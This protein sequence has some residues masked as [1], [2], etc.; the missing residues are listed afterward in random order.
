P[1][2]DRLHAARRIASGLFDRL[3]GD[4]VGIVV[5]AGQAFVQCPLTVDEGAARMLLGAIGQETVPLPGTAIGA[6]IDQASDVLGDE[7]PWRAIVLITD[8]EDHGGDPVAAARRAAERGI[9]IITVGIGGEAGELIPVLNESGERVGY[10][11]DQSGELVVSRLDEATLREVAEATGGRY[12]RAGNGRETDVIY[13]E[14]DAMEKRAI[15]GGFHAHYQDRFHIFA[16]AAFV[17]L[18]TARWLGERGL[19]R[20]RGG[21]RRAATRAT[22]VGALLLAPLGALGPHVAGATPAAADVERGN[23]A[24]RD[25]DPDAA[26]EHYLDALDKDDTNAAVHYNLGNAYHEAGEFEEAM[27]AYVRAGARADSGLAPAISYNLG[28]TLFREGRLQDAI[29]AYEQTLRR[30]PQDAD[31]K[32][33][34][35]VALQRLEEQQRQQDQSEQQDGEQDEQQDNQ[36]QPGNPQQEEQ[37][38]GEQ[39]QQGQQQSQEEQQENQQED[40]QQGQQ[41]DQQQ[42]QQQQ[43]QPQDDQ[44]QEQDDE[45][46]PQQDS[47]EQPENAPQAPAAEQPPGDQEPPA[48]MSPEDARRWLEALNDDELQLLRERFRSRRQRLDVEKDW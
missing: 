15:E 11:R 26:V 7:G 38:D 37:Q 6:A 4:R 31:A 25:G 30:T 44:R 28:N 42:G 36:Q 46:Q 13:E 12:V 3:R 23:A 24:L 5:F 45:P 20:R 33:N 32:W 2:S 14:I 27:A 48:G 16:V 22:V 8:G 18:A 35:E 1:D 47:A 17:L 21:A 39:S 43:E 34:L 40:Q 41:Q 10:K 29:E 9:R 19:G